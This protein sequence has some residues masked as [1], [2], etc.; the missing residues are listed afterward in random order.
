MFIIIIISFFILSHGHVNECVGLLKKKKKLYSKAMQTFELS[1]K[2]KINILMT[3]EI[4]SA[5]DE[6]EREAG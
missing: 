2:C 1:F 4:F 5:N 6:G 3:S